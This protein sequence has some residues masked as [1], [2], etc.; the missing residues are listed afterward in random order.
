MS[1]DLPMSVWAT[2][3]THARQQRANRYV[4]ESAN[5][6]GRMLPAIARAAISAYTSPGDLVLDPVCGVGTTLV[7]AIHL[8]RHAVG[9]EYEPVWA[10][11]ARANLEFAAAQGA[12]GGA[13][14]LLGTPFA[15]RS[16][17]TAR[18]AGQSAWS[19][20]LHPAGRR[21]TGRPRPVRAAASSGHTTG[22]RR[23]GRTWP[24]SLWAACSPRS[25]RSSRR[26][27]ICS[28]RA[29]SWP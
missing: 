5:H 10:D 22:I 12:S 23:T 24:I 7:E 2:A 9:V 28:A 1:A 8:G 4:R 15:R 26:A 17:S 21:C 27:E 16:W 18:S 11:I 14:S 6:P 20:P 29:A 13:K 25:P 3:Q 19:S